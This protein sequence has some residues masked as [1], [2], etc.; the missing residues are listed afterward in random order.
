V[1]IKNVKSF[2]KISIYTKYSIFLKM[3]CDL[4]KLLSVIYFNRN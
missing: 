2:M 3:T 4:F 1:I